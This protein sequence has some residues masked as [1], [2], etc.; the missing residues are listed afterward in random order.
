MRHQGMTSRCVISTCINNI[1]DFIP[2]RF[3]PFTWPSS[4]QDINRH[5]YL[6][7]T[8][9]LLYHHRLQQSMELLCSCSSSITSPMCDR[10]HAYVCFTPFLPT[11]RWDALIGSNAPGAKGT[12]A[13]YLPELAHSPSS[14]CAIVTLLFICIHLLHERHAITPSQMVPK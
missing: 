8:Q 11:A 6:G 10:I 12:S 7:S 2:P 14:H 13:Q 4:V 3:T 1:Y 9:P 5:R